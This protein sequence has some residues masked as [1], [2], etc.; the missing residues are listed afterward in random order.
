MNYKKEDRKKEFLLLQKKVIKCK[1][2]L[3]LIK[4]RYTKREL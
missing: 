4:K 1:L 2:S 3:N